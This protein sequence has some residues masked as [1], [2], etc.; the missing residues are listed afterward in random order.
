[1]T[2][3]SQCAELLAQLDALDSELQQRLAARG[4]RAKQLLSWAASLGGDPLERNRLPGAVRLIDQST[5]ADPPAR[6]TEARATAQAAGEQALRSGEVALCVLAGGMAT[7][8]GGVVKALMPVAREQSFLEL[9][10]AE[11][12]A[13]GERYGTSPPL[14]LM[15]SEPTDGAIRAALKTR[16][17]HAAVA[18]FEQLVSLRLDRDGTL[19]RDGNG[20]PSVYATG[21]GD[22]PEALQKSGLLERFN[23]SG[24]RFVW[25][26]NIDNLGAG[27]DPVLLGQHIQRSGALTVELVEK[28][29]GDKGGGPVLHDG[30]PI[31]AEHFRLPTDFDADA[32]TVFNTNTFLIDSRRLAQLDLAWTYLE[33]HKQVQGRAAIQFERLLGEITCALPA[34]FVRVSRAGTNSRFIPIK[35]REELVSAEPTVIKMMRA[36]GVELL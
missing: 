14:W 1:M 16:S 8:M 10:L 31:L 35:S 5:I 25:V 4:F 33:V 26:C 30:K 19:F 36:R 27:I 24:G 9:R 2:R 6:E 32:I 11:Q 29:P 15:T 12:A 18:T 34:D 28:Y 13:L 23:Q 21:H 3:A 20:A 22:L 17:G 7:R